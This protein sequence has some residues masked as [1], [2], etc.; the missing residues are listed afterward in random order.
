MDIFSALFLGVL[1]GITEFLP[2]S[3]SGHLVLAEHFMKLDV[4]AMKSFDVAVHFG[5]LLA[6]LIYF[7]KDFWALI[8]GSFWYAGKVLGIKKEMT[9]QLKDSAS[10]SG[11]I[12]LATVPA[13][14]VGLFFADYLDANFRNA[15]SVAVMMIAVGVLF[16]V[17]EYIAVRVAKTGLTMKNT[18]LIGVAQACALIPGVSRSGATISAGLAQGISREAAARFSFLLG[19]VAITAA[20]A[21]SLYHALKGEIA[22]PPFDLMSAGIASS[23]VSGYAAIAFLMRFLKKHTLRV[24]GVYRVV[25]GFALLLLNT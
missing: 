22:M 19:A 1:Q 15:N 11:W 9:P 10:L 24:F 23:F 8:K 3:S 5:T 16:F 25:V 18:I 21:L 13:V 6:I 2:I 17:A 20:S 14:I 4:E 7:R 12:I